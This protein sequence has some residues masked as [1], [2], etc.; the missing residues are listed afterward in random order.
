MTERDD[1]RT[2]DGPKITERGWYSI[3]VAMAVLSFVLAS[4]GAYFI[5]STATSELMVQRAQ[6]LG[7]VGVMLAAMVTFSTIAWRGVIASN[8]LEVQRQQI[9]QII[10]QND[11][12]DREVLAKILQDGAKLLDN[13][14]A[15]GNILAGVASLA[16]LVRDP[17]RT[18]SVE[19]MDVLGGFYVSSSAEKEGPAME[20][21]RR[22]LI[23]G[24]N[25]GL[26]TSFVGRFVASGASETKTGSKE[27]PQRWHPVSGFL[28][29]E[30]SGGYVNYEA[31]REIVHDDV[32]FQNTIISAHQIE[33]G[34]FR[35]CLFK[36]CSFQKI[37]WSILM[38][39]T[40]EDSDFSDT[41]FDIST[42]G[43]PEI[44]H[45]LSKKGNFFWDDRPPRHPTQK[46]D[47]TLFLEEQLNDSP[48]PGMFDYS[49]R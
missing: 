21:V 3:A 10:R 23:S 6:A 1:P 36:N 27:T 20:S 24:R 46:V 38:Y 26:S 16:V 37:D 15:P 30:Y 43:L 5:L 49:Q 40:F 19:A 48:P 12:K 31:Y 17:Q 44:I 22:A 4:I 39:N 28:R 34:R 33:I 45:I 7:P 8:Q 32:E 42:H 13:P 11:A 25:N 14:N 9:T 35:D 47:W 18:F 2:D 41:I 29:Q